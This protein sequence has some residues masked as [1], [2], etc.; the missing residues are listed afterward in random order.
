MIHYS[1]DKRYA[2][3]NSISFLSL[4]GIVDSEAAKKIQRW[5]RKTKTYETSVVT[6]EFDDLH[7]MHVISIESESFVDKYTQSFKRK[8]MRILL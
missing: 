4:K 7:D 2:I 5:W 8:C 1:E 6:I 3:I